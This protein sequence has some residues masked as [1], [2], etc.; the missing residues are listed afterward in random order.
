MLSQDEIIKIYKEM[1]IKSQVKNKWSLLKVMWL[2]VVL[3]VISIIIGIVG[4]ILW[5]QT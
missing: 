2:C 5:M 4:V 1:G 3:E